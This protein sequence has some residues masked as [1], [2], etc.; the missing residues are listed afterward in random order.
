MGINDEKGKSREDYVE[1]MILYLIWVL[2]AMYYQEGYIGWVGAVQTIKNLFH[3]QK[4]L[5][6]QTYLAPY[7]DSRD[8]G[9]TCLASQPFSDLIKHIRLLDRIPE[10]FYGH[11]RPPDRTCPTYP[12]SS[13]TKSRTGHIRSPSQVLEKLAGYVRPPT[14]TCPG[15]W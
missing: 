14:R 7:L 2:R 15:F 6:G 4:L 8:S 1:L 9:R 10:A 5:S 13:A 12:N 3:H 11:V